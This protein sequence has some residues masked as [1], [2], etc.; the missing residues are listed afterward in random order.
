MRSLKVISILVLAL[1]IPFSG[2]KKST[3]S[4]P[5]RL[6]GWAVGSSDGFYGTILHTEDGGLT[7]TRQGDSLL[8][9]NVDFADLCIIDENTLIA[10]GSSSDSV[11]AC[12]FR[13]FDRGNTWQRVVTDSLPAISYNGIYAIGRDHLWIV[14]ESGMIFHSND[15]GEHWKRLYPPYI[16]QFWPFFRVAARDPS[17]IW[18]VGDSYSADSF[19]VMLHSVDSGNSWIRL[20]PLKSMGIQE[21]KGGHYLGI[22]VYGNSIWAIGGF[23]KFVIRSTNEGENWS[24]VTAVGG[25]GDANDLFLYNDRIAYLVTDYNGIYYTNNA[26]TQWYDYSYITGDWYLGVAWLPPSNVWVVGSPGAGQAHSVIIHSPNDGKSWIDQTPPVLVSTDIAL[27]K[28]RFI[29]VEE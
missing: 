21:S 12:V 11:P 4:E 29:A 25:L 16:Y 28:V 13:S 2:C 6:L 24:N 8:F 9:A 26:G 22:K 5:V 18:V 27:Y 20:N 15:L 19:P 17:N 1:M 23:G 10:V 7:W 14:G 3:S